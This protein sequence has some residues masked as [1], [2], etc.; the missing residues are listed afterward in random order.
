MRKLF[1]FTVDNTYVNNN[2]NIRKSA[3]TLAEVL[4]TL[5][6]IGVVA[7]ITIPTLITKQN[8]K[9]F[10]T[11]KVVAEQK[12]R[13]ITRQMNLYGVLAPHI[14]TSS[15]INSLKDYVKIGQSCDSEHLTDCF[16]EQ[17]TKSSG[18]VVEIKDLKNSNKLGKSYS[19]FNH[20]F[21]ILDGLTFIMSYD[22]SCVAPDK[23]NST[24]STTECLSY[25]LDVNGKKGPNIVG[26]DVVL[27]NASLPGGGCD[28]IEFNDMCIASADID[29]SCGFTGSCETMGDPTCDCQAAANVACQ[30]IGM[31][32]PNAREYTQMYIH[33]EELGNPATATAGVML[34]PDVEVP[35]N[36][37]EMLAS[38]EYQQQMEAASD[39]EMQYAGM[40][41]Y[42]WAY[43]AGYNRVRCVK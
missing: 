8:E 42:A 26:E 38:E 29:Y 39:E 9:V 3:F 7:A 41:N 34:N 22:S 14:N 40:L 27:V 20:A 13:E 25:I 36:Y 2:N 35:D 17:I 23:Y 4:I 15:F 19:D 5:G 12:I 11:R 21:A 43:Q 28:G 37:E 16:A 24:L 33:R 31:R 6:I 1:N 18:E 32:A 10:K 30:A